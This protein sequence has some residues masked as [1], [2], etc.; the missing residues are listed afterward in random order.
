MNEL[1]QYLKDAAVWPGAFVIFREDWACDYFSVE[2]KCFCMLGKNGRGQWVMTVKGLP[3]KNELLREQYADVLP[4]YYANKT[5]WISFLL[6]NSSFSKDQLIDF[7]K[8]SYELVFRKLPK[9]V[10]QKYQENEYE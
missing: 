5:H 1:R 10:Q 4:G 2:Q 6:E 9:K 8:E 7:L 3:E